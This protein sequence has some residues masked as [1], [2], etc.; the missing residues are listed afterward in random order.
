[1][2]SH[3][4]RQMLRLQSESTSLHSHS[5]AR[6]LPPL[7]TSGSQLHAAEPR[8]GRRQQPA[9]VRVGEK[10]R[11]GCSGTRYCLIDF[12]PP[13]TPRTKKIAFP[14]SA[15]AVLL[16]FLNNSSQRGI[17]R[18][19][20]IFFSPETEI[21]LRPQP[22]PRRGSRGSSHEPL[23]RG[24][25]HTRLPAPPPG[26]FPLS[27]SRQHPKTIRWTC[28]RAPARRC[29]PRGRSAACAR[30]PHIPPACR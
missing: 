15:T 8:A 9:G 5:P 20:Y 16:G 14:P 25:E 6:G 17:P 27:S 7:R 28:P 23:P 1:M 21:R 24:R 13:P 26:P 22:P 12:R 11:G 29:E 3:L 19:I 10:K 18:K 4:V 30:K 2:A